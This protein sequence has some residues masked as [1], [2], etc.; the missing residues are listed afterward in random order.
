MDVKKICKNIFHKTSS[1]NWRKYVFLI[2]FMQEHKDYM[3]IHS[4]MKNTH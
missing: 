1:Q 2:E 4:V 3:C